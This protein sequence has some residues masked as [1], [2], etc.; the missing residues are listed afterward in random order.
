MIL[1]VGDYY[2]GTG[3]A[4]VTKYYIETL[5]GEK[6]PESG[7]RRKKSRRHSKPEADYLVSESKAARFFE[8]LFKIPHASVLFL[9][10]HSRQN[11]LAMRMHSHQVHGL[12]NGTVTLDD[13][14][15]LEIRDLYAFCEYVENRW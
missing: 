13:G 4:L 1:I 7:E 10:G 15:I 14:Q 3:P 6:V 11:I 9:S 5:T 12:W 8:L 2:S